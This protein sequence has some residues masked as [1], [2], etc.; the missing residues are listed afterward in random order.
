MC[1]T[2]TAMTLHK[3]LPAHFAKLSFLT[4]FLHEPEF[5]ILSVND[6]M[7]RY[8]DQATNLHISSSQLQ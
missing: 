5:M 2:I 1:V 7:Q 6:V 3:A 8:E 4:D